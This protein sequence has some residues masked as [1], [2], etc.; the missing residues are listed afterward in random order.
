MEKRKRK[1]KKE[2]D[3]AWPSPR[4]ELDSRR[5]ANPVQKFHSYSLA[6][7]TFAFPYIPKRPKTTTTIP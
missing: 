7:A 5:K 6:S 2:D 4:Q 3:V 1:E